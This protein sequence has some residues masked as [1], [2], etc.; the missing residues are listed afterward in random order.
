[1]LSVI[2]DLYDYQVTYITFGTLIFESHH[3]QTVVSL[4]VSPDH[5]L[6]QAPV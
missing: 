2:F 6:K 1:M 5:R 4:F 3:V